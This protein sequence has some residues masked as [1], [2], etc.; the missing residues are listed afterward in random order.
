MFSHS[1]RN[2]SND[3]DKIEEDSAVVFV[4][5]LSY[6]CE[7]TQLHT[8]MNDCG[9]VKLVRIVRNESNSRSLMYGFVTMA[10]SHEA[11]EMER[12]FDDHFFMGRKIR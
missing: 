9:H 10:S 3:V 12:L 7:E 8:L 4:G 6:F 1:D 2:N 11:R 5:N